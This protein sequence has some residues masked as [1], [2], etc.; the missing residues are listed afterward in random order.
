MGLPSTKKQHD[1]AWTIVERLTKFS[2]FLAI[3]MIESLDKLSQ[4]HIL[5]CTAFQKVLFVTG[6]PNSYTEFEEV[7]RKIYVLV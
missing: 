5:P 6:I 1:A 3:K 4:L 2:P 7:Y